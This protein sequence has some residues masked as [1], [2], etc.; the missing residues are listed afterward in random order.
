APGTHELRDHSQA[1]LLTST[2]DQ[3]TV[4]PRAVDVEV[5]MQ[6]PLCPETTPAEHDAAGEILRP[7][8]RVDP[9]QCTPTES[10]VHPQRESRGGHAATE[11]GAADPIPD[12]AGVQ[13]AT[14]DP[15]HGQLPAEPPV[16]LDG[17]RHR[18]PHAGGPAELGVDT[19]PGTARV[20]LVT[21]A[22]DGRLP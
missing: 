8:G 19:R 2:R 5:P 15:A 3:Q 7:D 17:R 14:H 11:E 10:M 18:V 21:L 16:Q 9:V 12:P 22:V 6:Q 20:A 13:R 1:V 4:L